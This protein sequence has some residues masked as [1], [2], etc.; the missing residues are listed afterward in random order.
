MNTLREDFNP[1]DA[2]EKI[3]LR[4][5]LR[6]KSAT[7]KYDP[8][9]MAPKMV[10]VQMPTARV[11]K[12]DVR[13]IQKDGYQRNLTETKV[14]KIMR[15]YDPLILGLPELSRRADGSLF[16]IDGQH[17]I[18]AIMRMD[19]DV[20]PLISAVVWTGLTP[21]Q[22]AEKFAK[23]Q[24]SR[25]R[26]AMLPESLH[27]AMVYARDLQ[28][29]RI[30]D[31]VHANGYR[32]GPGEEGR[33]IRAVKNLYD[34]EERY[35]ADMLDAV[36]TVIA[37]AWGREAHPE[38]PLMSGVALFIGMFPDAKLNDLIRRVSKKPLEHWLVD[39]EDRR[40]VMRIRSKAEA[41]ANLLH[42]EYNTTHH[43]NPLPDFAST[44]RGHSSEIRSIATKK[45][46]ARNAK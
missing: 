36:L 46:K 41:V 1:Y 20:S 44:L 19:G 26:S 3:N 33:R 27:N 40:R 25:N 32:I 39:V 30:E 6:G 42:H 16:V 37:S 4:D 5:I 28:A 12:I 10:Q 18:T 14:R 2:G 11:E 7:P 9:A 34:I 31:V 13:T 23:S 24:D 45:G 21:E 22:E 8:A 29:K 43:A 38:G 35:G 15:E 17:R